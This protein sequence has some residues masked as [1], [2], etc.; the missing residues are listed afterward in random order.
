METFSAMKKSTKERRDRQLLGVGDDVDDGSE[1]DAWSD[2][3][4]SQSVLDGSHF[5]KLS[6]KL[7]EPSVRYRRWLRKP[8]GKPVG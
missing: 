8:E 7:V 2:L 3:D 1:S 6:A 4:E 5:A